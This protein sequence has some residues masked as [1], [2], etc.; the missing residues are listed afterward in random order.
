MSSFFEA[1]HRWIKAAEENLPPQPVT[2]QQPP[3]HLDWVNYK[4]D[5]SD[6][7]TESVQTIDCD[8]L[9]IHTN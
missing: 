4:W 1:T 8:G 2:P 3:W 6:D 5:K 7:T 9:W